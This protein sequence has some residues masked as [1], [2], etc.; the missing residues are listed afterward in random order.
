MGSCQ[1]NYSAGTD[2]L[3]E[4]S[5]LGW[6]ELLAEITNLDS[7]MKPLSRTQLP[8]PREKEKERERERERERTGGQHVIVLTIDSTRWT[9]LMLTMDSYNPPSC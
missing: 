8:T 5:A 3:C 1:Q 4:P 6:V 7:I 2:I 9:G